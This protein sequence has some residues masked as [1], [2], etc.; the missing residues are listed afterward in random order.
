MGYGSTRLGRGVQQPVMLA[1]HIACHRIILWQTTQYAAADSGRLLFCKDIRHS[2][3][4]FRKLL[5]RVGTPQRCRSL[6]FPGGRPATAPSPSRASAAT[7]VSCSFPT[8]AANRAARHTRCRG[9]CL[10]LPGGGAVA[11]ILATSSELQGSATNVRRTG[12][13]AAASYGER[14]SQQCYSRHLHL[15]DHHASRHWI[16]RRSGW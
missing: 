15:V 16:D 2:N 8:A 11:L 4:G 5:R 7:R 10:A 6:R 12:A 3:A 1:M 9:R 13:S 14:V